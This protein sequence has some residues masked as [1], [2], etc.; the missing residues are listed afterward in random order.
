MLLQLLSD[1]VLQESSNFWRWTLTPRGLVVRSVVVVEDVI[2]LVVA[3]AA[4]VVV[5]DDV[6][7]STGTT[8]WIG[9]SIRMGKTSR[10]KSKWLC[11][12]IGW[13]IRSWLSDSIGGGW[14]GRHDIVGLVQIT[15]RTV[16][17]PIWE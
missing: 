10:P 3:A 5:V 14:I 16:C 9:S 13:R 6:I 7:E 1:H 8:V 11:V 15:A 17:H 4:T 12:N 2:A